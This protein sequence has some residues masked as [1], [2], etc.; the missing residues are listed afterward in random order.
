MPTDYEGIAFDMRTQTELV[1]SVVEDFDLFVTDKGHFGSL[2]V[3]RRIN[4]RNEKSRKAKISANLRWSNANALRTQSEGI[5]IKKEIK[6]EKHINKGN[7]ESFHTEISIACFEFLKNDTP[8]ILKMKEPLTHQQI[9]KLVN[10]FGK[11]QIK[12]ILYDMQNYEKLLETSTSANLTIRKWLRK[13]AKENK[14]KQDQ[15]INKP[16]SPLHQGLMGN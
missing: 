8:K 13:N 12:E 3:E 16:N 2:S 15:Q 9:N 6:K 14:T 10:D 4:E 5:A 1:R 7:D 11:D